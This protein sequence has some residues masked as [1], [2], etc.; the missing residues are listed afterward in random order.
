MIEVSRKPTFRR[1]VCVTASDVRPD[2]MYPHPTD[3]DGIA[4]AKSACEFC[5]VAT[6]CLLDA[7]A[8]PTSKDQ[9]GVRGGTTAEERKAM[10]KRKRRLTREAAQRAAAAAA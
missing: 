9:A 6:E 8:L 3:L 5:S 2:D 7:L 10:R 1:G 4:F